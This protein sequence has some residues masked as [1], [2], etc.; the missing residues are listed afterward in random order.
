VDGRVEWWVLESNDGLI[1]AG[2]GEWWHR[3]QVVGTKAKWWMLK[4]NGGWW[5]QMVGGSRYVVDAEAE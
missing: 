4:P 1:I 3:R 5:R 2:R